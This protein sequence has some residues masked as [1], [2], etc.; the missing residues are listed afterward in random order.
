[1]VAK[2]VLKRNILKALM[3]VNT[4]DLFRARQVSIVGAFLVASANN[5]AHAANELSALFIAI[6]QDVANIPEPHAGVSYHQ[7]LPNGDHYWSMT[8]TS[9]IVATYGGG[10]N[11]ATQRECLDM[12]GCAGKGKVNKFAKICA[13]GLE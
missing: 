8:L 4:E 3:G 11:L 12:L 5:G 10:T 7:L 9:L 13:D 2:A 6:G 1:M